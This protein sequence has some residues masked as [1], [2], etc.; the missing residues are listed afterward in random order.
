MQTLRR[1]VHCLMQL[2]RP[3]L[4]ICVALAATDCSVGEPRPSDRKAIA[5]GIALTHL[6]QQITEFP[7]R[8]IVVSDEWVEP[9]PVLTGGIWYATDNEMLAAPPSDGLIA[10]MEEQRSKSVI[11]QCPILQSYLK[12]NSIDYGSKAVDKVVFAGTS[13]TAVIIGL[14]QSVVSD[15]GKEALIMTSTT[16]G[17]LA[18]GGFL[19]HLK[20]DPAG[21]WTVVARSGLW[22][23]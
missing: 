11:E 2:V 17:P 16:E 4:S 20:K 10:Q 23:S 8:R 6:R 13:E 18:G 3:I 1:W 12:N 15:D 22:V 5:C 9:F 14:S 19:E 7:H 21:Q